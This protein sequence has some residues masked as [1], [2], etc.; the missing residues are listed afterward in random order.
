MRVM[1]LLIVGVG[2]V[3]IGALMAFNAGGVAN[4]GAQLSA[5]LGFLSVN[6]QPR[7]WRFNGAIFAVVGVL[8]AAGAAVRA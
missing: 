7:T 6:S 1:Q 5:K 3:L 2:L 8:I 4:K